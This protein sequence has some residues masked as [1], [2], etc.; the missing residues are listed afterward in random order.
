VLTSGGLYDLAKFI[1][2]L[3][4]QLFHALVQLL[5]YL[6][7][8]P[9]IRHRPFFIR[10]FVDAP[11]QYGNDIGCPKPNP[12]AL[13]TLSRPF[14]VRFLRIRPA[15]AKRLPPVGKMIERKYNPARVPGF[16]YRP[17]VPVTGIPVP[18]RTWQ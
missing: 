2:Y 7:V 11:F 15:G 1:M 5:K 4:I 12:S 14:I 10:L 13:S 17:S 8:I 6:R 3:V 9:V 18:S 16:F